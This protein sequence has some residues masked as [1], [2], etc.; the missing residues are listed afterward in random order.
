MN[1]HDAM[2]LNDLKQA[3]ARLDSRVD[4]DLA[5]ME[6]VTDALAEDHTR[7]LVRRAMWLP[8]MELV[9]E[10]ALLIVGVRGLFFGGS[11]VYFGC[12]IATLAFLVAL[13]AS[14]VWQIVTIAR[15]DPAAPV[16][17]T[18]RQLARV[19]T[20]RIFEAKWVLL[21]SPVIWAPFFVVGVELLLKL[22]FGAQATD[23]FSGGYLL[24]NLLIGLVL[25]AFLWWISRKIADRY[26]DS[27]FIS[28]LL[29]DLA[30]RRLTA[31][32]AFLSR[33][34]RFERE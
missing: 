1:K 13:M 2:D 29:D 10:G 32:R 34:D 8:T 24:A 11:A 19:R 7:T 31:A 16:V 22:I 21:F 30:G 17:A 33:L 14:A 27:S 26:R 12:L 4:T 28:R 20:L 5:K 25:T 23:I 15:V 6:E 18:Q 3:W 9:V